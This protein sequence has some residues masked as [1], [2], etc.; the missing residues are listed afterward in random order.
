MRRKQAA[1]L[2]ALLLMLALGASS[3]SAVTRTVTIRVNGMT[4]GGCAT[5]V[6]RALKSTEGVTDVRVSFEKGKAVIKFDDRKV[7]VARLR[8]VIN[9][10]GMSCDAEGATGR[11]L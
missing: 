11:G 4:C 10:T 2:T 8:E 9:G 5:S 7:T 1:V 6:E 3:V